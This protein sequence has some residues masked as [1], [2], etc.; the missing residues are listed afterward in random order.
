MSLPRLLFAVCCAGLIA[1]VAPPPAVADAKAMLVGGHLPVC[2]SMSPGQC[3]GR[4]HF[5][6]Q[7]RQADQ[8]QLDLYGLERW[9]QAAPD[10]FSEQQIAH[11]TVFLKALSQRHRRPMTRSEFRHRVLDSE[12]AD[13][14]GQTRQGHALYEALDDRQWQHLLDHFQLPVTQDEQVRLDQSANRSSIAIFEHFVAL[15]AEH[16]E[17]ERPLIAVSTASSS[18]PYDALA[19]YLAVFEQAGAD[20]V[21]LPLDAAVL[22]ARAHNECDQLARH[23]AERLG[24]FNRDQVW[25]T[26]YQAQQAFCD[27]PEAGLDIARQADGLFLNG[28][29]QWLTLQAFLRSDGSPSPEWA[30]LQERLAAGQLALGGTSAGAAVQSGPGMISNGTNAMA[31]SQ[32]ATASAPP[33]R[34]CDRTG[35][36][37]PGLTADS[38][39]WRPEGGLSSVPFAIVDTHFSE[40]QR[41]IRLTR[42]LHD[43][44]QRYGIGVDE[45]TAIVFRTLEDDQLAFAVIG[46]QAAWLLDTGLASNPPSQDAPTFM[47][48]MHRLPSGLSG[49]LRTDAPVSTSI[50]PWAITDLD[51]PGCQRWPERNSFNQII[52]SEHASTTEIVMQCFLT[53]DGHWIGLE[54]LAIAS[55]NPPTR[56]QHFRFGLAP[57]QRA[58][59]DE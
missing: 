36:C 14:T 18:D 38:L 31:L 35:R 2:S 34:G 41:Q 3:R 6:A 11:W 48:L 53:T 7:A 1:M 5:S 51:Q 13:G 59:A 40:R 44:G 56:S 28:G 22:A 57:R 32:G 45:T 24:R 12:F 8:F 39:T 16:S 49:V 52:R 47:T 15:A 37:P 19:F 55:D 46:E 9:S 54:T 30:V 43:S 10:Y 23:Q 27:D 42:L 21:W 50:D 26:L 29:D 4:A 58:E 20:V 33:E 25:A 17:R